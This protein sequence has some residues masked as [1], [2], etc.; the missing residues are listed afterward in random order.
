MVGIV[1]P[2]GSGKSSI[3]DGIS[4]ALYGKTPRLGTETVGLINQRRNEGKVSLTFSVGDSV[5]KV[6]RALRRKGPSAHALYRV[7]DGEDIEVSDKAREVTDKVEELLGLD[8]EGFSRSILLAQG[9]FAQFLDA[10]SVERDKVLK[11]VFGFERIDAMREIAKSKRDQA[12]AGLKALERLREQADEDRKT[13]E[14]VTTEA[15]AATALVGKLES[16]LDPVAAADTE[17]AAAVA[18]AIAAVAERDALA[19][20]AE[21][22]PGRSETDE[23]LGAVEGASQ[24]VGEAEAVAQAAAEAEAAARSALDEAIAATGGREALA[25]ARALLARHTEQTMAAS[26]AES[27]T[28]QAVEDAAA[29]EVAATE[30]ATAAEVAEK[31]RKENAAAVAAAA[32]EAERLAR[33][34]HEAQH[35]DLASTLR[36]DLADGDLCPVCEQTSPK[37]RR[38]WRRDST[39]RPPP[40]RQRWHPSKHSGV[41]TRPWSVT[42]HP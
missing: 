29:G 11:G 36:R 9:Q 1:G 40:I 35:R 13:L 15:E 28:K 2:I 41:R 32:K 38:L 39:K 23:L 10:T 6:V 42:Q 22:I 7:E 25:A 37:C 21:R 20:L 19:A 3:L 12:G 34:L 8:Y 4:F 31:A 24:A 17:I 26:R 5:W 14:T 16:A 33:A 27:Q 30:A 18:A